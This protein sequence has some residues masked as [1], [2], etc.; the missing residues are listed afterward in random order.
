METNRTNKT[1]ATSPRASKAR[2][3]PRVLAAP[4]MLDRKFTATRQPDD[5]D[6]EYEARC[7]LFDVLL[8]SAKQG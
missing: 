8:E 4:G 1:R 7:K 3:R 6:A 2:Q 5:T